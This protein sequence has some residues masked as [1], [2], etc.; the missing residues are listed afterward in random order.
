MGFQ[1]M[2]TSIENECFLYMY[3]IAYFVPGCKICMRLRKFSTRTVLF[4][5]RCSAEI[6]NE[7]VI[8][9]F[10]LVLLYLILFMAAPT[11]PHTQTEHTMKKKSGSALC[12]TSDGNNYAL[13]KIFLSIFETEVLFNCLKKSHIF[14]FKSNYFKYIIIKKCGS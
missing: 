7:K 14:L 9:G 6:N 3:N 4:G 13:Q 8:I 11:P 2:T 5:L 12:F 1:S 10:L